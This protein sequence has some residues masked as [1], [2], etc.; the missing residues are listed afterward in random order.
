MNHEQCM[1]DYY[2]LLGVL[3]EFLGPAEQMFH[4]LAFQQTYRNLLSIT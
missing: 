2:N 3:L 4:T 1:L